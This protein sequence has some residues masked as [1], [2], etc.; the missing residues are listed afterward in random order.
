MKIDEVTFLI[1]FYALLLVWISLFIYFTFKKLE[2][3]D[4]KIGFYFTIAYKIITNI[5]GYSYYYGTNSIELTGGFLGNP[6]WLLIPILAFLS[7]VI[8]RIKFGKKIPL[9][10]HEKIKKNTFLESNDYQPD[11][12]IEIDSSEG[13]IKESKF[14]FIELIRQ[15]K[16]IYLGAAIIFLLCILYGVY[17]GNKDQPNELTTDTSEK[18]ISQNVR[19][20]N[21]DID[22][23]P[24]GFEEI[25]CEE[26]LNNETIVTALFNEGLENATMV[27][28]KCF[29]K[30]EQNDISFISEVI[31]YP[32][33]MEEIRTLKLSYEGTGLDIYLKNNPEVFLID[34]YQQ[35]GDFSY[36]VEMSKI[37]DEI[38]IHYQIVSVI[39]ND[40]LVILI[41]AGLN[42]SE[43]VDLKG[44]ISET[45]ENIN[46]LF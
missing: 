33:T 4:F 14:D 40:F 18:N 5:I 24:F 8:R 11:K 22:E 42:N 10:N 12:P 23:I 38:P 9:P 39:K 31:L 37:E 25:S 16:Y 30:I 20:S 43:I 26:G 41:K 44:L 1:F 3:S 29:S 19:V 7:S 17:F 46:A 35:F 34:G 13:K 36:G 45:L 2:L 32:L 27:Y 15:D 28:S 21:I 6:D